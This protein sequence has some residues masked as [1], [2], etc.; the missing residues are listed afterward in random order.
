MAFR[1]VGWCSRVE[2]LIDSVSRIPEGQDSWNFDSS[3]DITQALLVFENVSSLV[4]SPS[5]PLPNDSILGIEAEEHNGTYVFTIRIASVNATGDSQTVT[6]SL[7]AS[8]VFLS[9][10]REPEREIRT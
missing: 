6:I 7:N 4:L 3:R 5:G 8:G 10:P 9:D 1:V 2:F